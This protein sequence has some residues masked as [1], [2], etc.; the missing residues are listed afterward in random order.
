VLLLALDALGPAASAGLWRG[1]APLSRADDP[2][3]AGRADA[4]ACLAQRALAEAGAGPDALDAIAVATGPGGF[5]GAR[6]AVALAR[7]LSMAC[8]APAVGVSLFEAAAHGRPG[9]VAVTLPG[10]GGSLWT[11]TLRD[12]A[13]EGPPRPA[14]PWAEA[15]DF[16]R[17]GPLAAVAA[18]G[19]LRLAA[20]AHDRPAPLYLRPAD[21][22]P[23]SEGPAPL[24]P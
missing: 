24:L 23:P 4:L 6:I 9:R 1:G 12:G 17:D 8:G 2:A 18:A 21:A 22:A 16:G 14:D 13:P 7:G 3:A 20:G 5:T 19:A 11:Q 15:H 10:G